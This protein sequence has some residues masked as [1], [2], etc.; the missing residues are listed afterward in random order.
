MV[1]ESGIRRRADVELLQHAGVD[2]M[3]VGE[4]LMARADIV[5]AVDELLGK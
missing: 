5:A 2:A 3:L 1:G 4:T